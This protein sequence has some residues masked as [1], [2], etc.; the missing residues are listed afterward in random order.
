MSIFWLGQPYCWLRTWVPSHGFKLGHEFIGRD[1][2][3]RVVGYAQNPALQQFLSQIQM[4]LQLPS[5][6]EKNEDSFRWIEKQALLD[7]INKPQSNGRRQV[8][9]KSKAAFC[10]S[11]PNSLSLQL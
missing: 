8:R 1:A 4:W 11:V 5:L 6:I 3:P 2:R 10:C 7:P 9:L